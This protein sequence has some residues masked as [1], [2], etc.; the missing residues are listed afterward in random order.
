MHAM[1]RVDKDK[2][3]Y[4]TTVHTLFQ[5]AVTKVF[6]PVAIIQYYRSE[7]T[8]FVVLYLHE[9][10]YTVLCCTDAGRAYFVSRL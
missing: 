2:T 1:E 10:Y 8:V 7:G 5:L 3:V 4:S 9:L 6:Y